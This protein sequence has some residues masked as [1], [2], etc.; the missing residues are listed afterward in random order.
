MASGSTSEGKMDQG[1]R[2]LSGRGCESVDTRWDCM[3]SVA[4]SAVDQGNCI[5]HS[6]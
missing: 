3:T 5:P 6:W 2:G 4:V 1:A